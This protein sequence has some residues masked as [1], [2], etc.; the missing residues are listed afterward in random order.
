MPDYD[1]KFAIILDKW[2]RIYPGRWP[3]SEFRNTL[4][5]ARSASQTSGNPTILS[6]NRFN[7]IIEEDKTIL[8]ARTGRQN[9]CSIYKIEKI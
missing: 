8:D 5:A 6:K 2:K 1:G 9:N 7:A 4:Q 3:V